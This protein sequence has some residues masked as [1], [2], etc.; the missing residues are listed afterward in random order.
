MCAVSLEETPALLHHG[1]HT[2]LCAYRKKLAQY[3]EAAL[4]ASSS[5][6]AMHAV[7]LKGTEVERLELAE[8]FNDPDANIMPSLFH[9]SRYA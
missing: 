8:W 3:N 2:V 9:A 6:F 4:L 1:S 5:K 7:H